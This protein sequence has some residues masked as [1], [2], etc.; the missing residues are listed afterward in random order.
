MMELLIWIRK[1][2]PTLVTV[3]IH[4]YVNEMLTVWDANTT[5]NGGKAKLLV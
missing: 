5:T 4:S 3:E 1:L 2:I